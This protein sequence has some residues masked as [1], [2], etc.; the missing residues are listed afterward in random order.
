MTPA[1]NGR[2]HVTT[3]ETK[4]KRRKARA[5]ARK[6]AYDGVMEAYIREISL[7]RAARRSPA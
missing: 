3:S 5:R 7:S 4:A 2:P 1:D 6:L